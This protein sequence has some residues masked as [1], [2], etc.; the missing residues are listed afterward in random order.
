MSVDGDVL[1]GGICDFFRAWRQAEGEQRQ[2]GKIPRCGKLV[3]MSD[4]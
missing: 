1:V 3:T 4:G 2:N